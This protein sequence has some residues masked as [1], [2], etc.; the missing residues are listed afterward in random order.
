MLQVADQVTHVGHTRKGLQIV[1]CPHTQGHNILK[2]H[3]VPEGDNLFEPI[4]QVLTVHSVPGQ[5]VVIASS[6]IGP[7]GPHFLTV[8]DLP[9]EEERSSEQQFLP[10]VTGRAETPTAQ[11]TCDDKAHYFYP[12]RVA[13][14][15]CIILGASHFLPRLLSSIYKMQYLSAS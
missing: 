5:D 14:L 6:S 1:P 3:L 4:R 12:G 10:V 9:T 13:Q 8:W 11:V 7:H 2:P 15:P